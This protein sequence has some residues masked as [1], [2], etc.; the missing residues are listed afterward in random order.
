MIDWMLKFVLTVSVLAWL[1]TPKLFFCKLWL[2]FE[3]VRPQTASY[4][5]SWIEKV[6]LL[7]RYEMSDPFHFQITQGWRWNPFVP[8]DFCFPK[9]KLKLC[10]VRGWDEDKWTSD[11]YRRW[12]SIILVGEQGFPWMQNNSFSCSSSWINLKGGASGDT[13][14]W[15]KG[16]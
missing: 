8:L 1:V 13:F 12:G 10:Q 9:D 14:F 2:R 7:G 11:P 15:F 3:N 6:S 4:V 5:R 16:P